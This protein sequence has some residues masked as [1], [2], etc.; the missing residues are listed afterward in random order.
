MCA[1]Y[2]EKAAHC[3]GFA[4][5]KEIHDPGWQQSYFF[6]VILYRAYGI[7]DRLYLRPNFYLICEI[8]PTQN[9][10]DPIY[11]YW[12]FLAQHI[13]NQIPHRN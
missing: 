5:A 13:C 6:R 2:M 3:A 8:L 11:F 7:K 12:I 4:Q 9:L 10:E 1:D